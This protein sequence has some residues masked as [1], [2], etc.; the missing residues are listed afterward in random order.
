MKGDEKLQK[1][2]IKER[3]PKKVKRE[4]ARDGE[5]CNKG[6]FRVDRMEAWKLGFKVKGFLRNYKDNC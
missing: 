2:N 6:P 5:N 1:G 4:Y 3:G